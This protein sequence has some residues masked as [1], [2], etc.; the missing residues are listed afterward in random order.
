MYGTG[1]LMVAALIIGRAGTG[2]KG[3]CEKFHKELLIPKL[4]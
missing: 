4:M 3:I 2:V 1:M